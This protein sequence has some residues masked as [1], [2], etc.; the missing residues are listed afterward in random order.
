[1]TKPDK[2]TRNLEE[3]LDKYKFARPV[4]EDARKEILASKKKN[5]VR[6]L[7]SVGA[8]SALYGVLLSVYFVLKKLGV[9]IPFA[10]LIISGLTAAAV[11]YGGYYAVTA[12]KSGHVPEASLVKKEE[13]LQPE[14]NQQWVDRITLYNGRVIEGA[15]ISRGVQYRVRTAAG[16]IQ[17]PRNRIKMIKPLKVG[18]EA[19]P[20]V[21]MTQ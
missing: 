14:E 9:S 7:K 21:P 11:T 1:M 19:K 2:D 6:V 5:L 12:L 17:V 8:F 4:P 15:V 13:P 3:L 16:I 18:T 10:K 20:V